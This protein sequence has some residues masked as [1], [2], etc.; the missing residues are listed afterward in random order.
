MYT[1]VERSP[2]SPAKDHAAHPVRLKADTVAVAPE[3]GDLAALKI[4]CTTRRDTVR[5]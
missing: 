5:Y 3:S 4:T 1:F 2:H